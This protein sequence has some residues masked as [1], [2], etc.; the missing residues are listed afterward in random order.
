M[1]TAAPSW[2]SAQRLLPFVADLVRG[3]DAYLEMD[4]MSVSLGE[5]RNSG[6]VRILRT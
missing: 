4:F 1:A 5:A 2:W 3:I 6:V